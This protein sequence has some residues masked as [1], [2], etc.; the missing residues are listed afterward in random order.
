M[1]RD[2]GFILLY[3]L[4]VMII[5]GGLA[6]TVAY[7][8]RIGIELVH[9][10]VDGVRDEYALRSALGLTE[11]QLE[12]GDKLDP[13]EKVKDPVAERADRW[14]DGD[15]RT[16][17]IGDS[18][19]VI[20][21]HA[22]PPVPDFNLFD[23]NDITRLFVAM[24][25]GQELAQSY[26]KIVLAAKP[27]GSGYPDRAA[28]TH[29]D[30]IPP[31]VLGKL[32]AGDSGDGAHT[33]VGLVDVGSGRKFIDLNRTPLPVIAALSGLSMEKL[34][35]LRKL[36]Q[37]GPVL[38]DDATTQVGAELRPLLA[39]ASDMLA[40]FELDGTDTWADVRLTHEQNG[41]KSAP[42]TLR[43]GPI[44]ADNPAGNAPGAPS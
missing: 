32:D 37:A 19:V 21:L 1:R 11:A 35:T 24:G 17:T 40:H 44:E 43:H 33:L 23:E 42:L 10:V 15:R 2:G 31:E 27:P 4:A 34:E 38:A 16:V 39:S 29:I 30:V 12:L 22:L 5:L 20:A 25:F 6:L 8:E 9:N 13:L 7:R 18:K 26:A 41:W 36:R 28:L 14:R 3:V